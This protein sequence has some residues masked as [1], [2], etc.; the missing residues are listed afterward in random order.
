MIVL[1]R[2][3][4]M[5]GRGMIYEAI[6]RW[7]RVE[8]LDPHYTMCRLLHGKGYRGWAYFRQWGNPSWEMRINVAKRG[9]H[10]VAESRTRTPH[11]TTYRPGPA[12]RSA[13]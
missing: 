8:N 13:L 7:G 1:V 9:N 11:V 5:S 6:C 12:A 3:L 2:P 10:T 4:H